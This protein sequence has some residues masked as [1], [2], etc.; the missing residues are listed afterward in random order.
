MTLFVN[1]GWTTLI[2]DSL[3]HRTV[4][5][6]SFL[7]GLL[8]AVIAAI[9]AAVSFRDGYL[10]AMASL[11]ALLVGMV[12]SSIVFSGLHSCID[13]VIVLYAEAPQELAL[14]HPALSQKMNES[15][16]QAY[17]DLFSV[18]PATNSMV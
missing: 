13:T 14:H 15:W 11:L 8:T 3:L 16:S 17:P 7:I 12:I 6:M 4:A 9:L 1:R 10:I 2:T 18:A 5:L